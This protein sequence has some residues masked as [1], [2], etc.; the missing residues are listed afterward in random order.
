MIKMKKKLTLKKL[1]IMAF[2]IIFGISYT[3]QIITMNRIENEI[4]KKQAELEELTEKNERLQEEVEKIDLNSESYI[5]KLARERLGMI[6]P[7]EK[8]INVET[9][10]DDAK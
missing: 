4:A 1:I 3:R 5:E 7:G 6:K 10:E 8:V 2:L 9:T